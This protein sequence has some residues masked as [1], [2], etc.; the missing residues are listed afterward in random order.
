MESSKLMK[1]LF[2]GNSFNRDGRRMRAVFVK[3][4]SDGADE[5]RLWRGAGK[6]DRDYASAENDKYYL[7]AEVNGYLAPIGLTEAM[8][9]DRCGIEA[10]GERYGGGEARRSYLDGLRKTEGMEAYVAALDE[11]RKEAGCLGGD[12]AR[13]AAYIRKDLDSHVRTY[14]ESRE[15]GG[16]SFPDFVGALVLDDLARCAELSATYKARRREEDQA[17]AAHAAEKEKAFCE[18]R[19]GIAGQAIADAVRII[20]EGGELEN[21]KVLYFNAGMMAVP[22]YDPRSKGMTFVQRAKPEHQADFREIESRHPGIPQ[23][24]FTG[25]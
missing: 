17:R 3:S 24:E 22:C 10:V 2:H 14:L 9:T 13:Q 6:P 19:N 20:R 12:P 21:A 16:K 8:L 11:E 4:V 5:Y 1:P 18:E 7:Y 25:I 15:S 23:S